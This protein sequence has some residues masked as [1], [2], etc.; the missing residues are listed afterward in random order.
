MLEQCR[1]T[2][3][4]RWP[5]NE[6][7][8]SGVVLSVASSVNRVTGCFPFWGA[9]LCLTLSMQIV[10]PL[11]HGSDVVRDRG[12]SWID[13]GRLS[14]RRR[15]GGAGYGP[16]GGKAQQEGPAGSLGASGMDV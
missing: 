14:Q 8:T 13:L 9:R 2:G 10:R 16:D 3:E 15:Y 4:R 11:F 12:Q 7:G 6:D 1:H 5:N